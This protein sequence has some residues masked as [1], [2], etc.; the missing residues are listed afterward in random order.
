MNPKMSYLLYCIATIL[1]FFGVMYLLAAPVQNTIPRLTAGSIL[2]IVGIVMIAI[3][4]LKA[5]E[6]VEVKTTLELP[7]G[8]DIEQLKCKECGGKLNKDSLHFDPKTGTITVVC[9]YCGA[10]YQLVDDVKW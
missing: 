6:V 1:L 7:A 8:I 3:T 10:V 9:P 2:V 5:K 4:H